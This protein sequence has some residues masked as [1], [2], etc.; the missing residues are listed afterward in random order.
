[1]AERPDPKPFN[2]R[3]ETDALIREVGVWTLGGSHPCD[4]T[5]FEVQCV[6]VEVS[7]H[8]SARSITVDRTG[9]PDGGADEA[10][11]RAVAA[12]VVRQLAARTSPE[13]AAT[14]TVNVND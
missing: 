10:M 4:C 11:L 8:K 2:Y 3:G 5:W 13:W 12:E 1:M 14:Y 9:D 7:C 6:R